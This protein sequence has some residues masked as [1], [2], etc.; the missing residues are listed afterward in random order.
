MEHIVSLFLFLGIAVWE[1]YHTQ[2]ISNLLILTALFSALLYQ[3]RQ[4]GFQGVSKALFHSGLILLFLFP[5]F[6]CKALGAGDIKLLGVTAAYLFWKAAFLAFLAGI[7]L[8]L[9]PIAFSLL[10]KEKGQIKKIPMSGP[11]VGGI[12]LIIYKEGCT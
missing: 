4:T 2:K 11:L 9:I 12:L 7:Y 3:F 10:R 6:L 1:D 8:S 5:L